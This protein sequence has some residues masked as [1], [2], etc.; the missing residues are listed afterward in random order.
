MNTMTTI[1]QKAAIKCTACGSI[2]LVDPAWPLEAVAVPSDEPGAEDLLD[3]RAVHL[4]HGIAPS[5]MVWTFAELEAE[6]AAAAAA[7]QPVA[8]IT[9]A[10]ASLI[11]D[12]DGTARDVLTAAAAVWR[13]AREAER[14]AAAAARTAIRFAAAEGMSES[15]VARATG[16][17]RLTVRAA[18]G[19]QDR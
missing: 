3:V 16:I 14:L 15:E 18:L 9:D 2:P 6:A 11:V 10:D 19:K 8:V 7:D 12:A 1:H 13:H 4:E 17:A 5:G